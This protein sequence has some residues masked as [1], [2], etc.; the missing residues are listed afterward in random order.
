MFACHR[1]L[2]SAKSNDVSCTEVETTLNATGGIKYHWQP[3]NSLSNADVPNPVAMPNDTTMYYVYVT[4]T[5]GCSRQDSIEVAVSKTS[6]QYFIP[7]AFTPNGDGLNDCFGVYKWGNISNLR[8]LIY[9]LW[10]EVIF[11]TSDFSKCWDG[12]R[13]GVAQQTGT[14]IFLIQGKTLCGNI[15]RKGAIILLR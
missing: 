1:R 9:N 12:T 5:N 10:G 3:E 14:Y 7:N 8:F 15:F 13:H 6:N 2:K 11:S 4:D